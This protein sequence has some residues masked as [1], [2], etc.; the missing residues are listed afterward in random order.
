[1]KK[2]LSFAFLAI[3]VFLVGCTEDEPSNP[4]YY[5]TPVVSKTTNAFAYS[6]SAEYYTSTA[7]YDLQFG[8]DSLAYSLIISSYFSGVGSIQLKDSTGTSIFEETL[9]GNK[10]IAFTQSDQGIPVRIQINFDSF[11]GTVVF[12]LARVNSN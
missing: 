4:G 6:V 3:A 5:N 12:S 1:M 9:Q 11:T 7:E 8:S 2:I 10:I